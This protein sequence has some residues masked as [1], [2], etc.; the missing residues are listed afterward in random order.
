LE[1]SG[2][3]RPRG[4][5]Q[6]AA[7]LGEKATIWSEALGAVALGSI[8]ATA[9]PVTSP[10]RELLGEFPSNAK[11]ELETFAREHKAGIKQAAAQAFGLAS[12]AAWFLALLA[13]AADK[14]QGRGAQPPSPG[15]HPSVNSL[16][17]D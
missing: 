3:D 17:E 15:N 8:F 14:L 1:L 12:A 5:R 11:H 4:I 2:R 7:N 9:I 6:T 13:I 16:T 10:E